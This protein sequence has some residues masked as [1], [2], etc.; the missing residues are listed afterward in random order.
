MVGIL[1]SFAFG[2]FTPIFQGALATCSF[3]WRVL[4]SREPILLQVE[5]F[6]AQRLLE[7]RFLGAKHMEKAGLVHPKMV[8]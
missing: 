3:P 1:L 5:N 4:T 8:V 6:R 2:S 7:T